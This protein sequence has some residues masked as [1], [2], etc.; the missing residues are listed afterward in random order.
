V[1]QNFGRLIATCEHC[2]RLCVFCALHGVRGQVAARSAVWKSNQVTG[3]KQEKKDLKR[4]ICISIYKYI[5]LVTLVTLVT[6]IY[7]Y[8]IN[9]N[10]FK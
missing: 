10:F 8:M 4:E 9:K 1:Y 6:I 3:N 7:K 5:Y 2:T